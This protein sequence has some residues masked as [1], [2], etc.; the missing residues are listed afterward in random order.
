MSLVTGLVMTHVMSQVLSLLLGLLLSP[1]SPVPGGGRLVESAELIAMLQAVRE[2]VRARNP[3]TAGGAADV[4][5]PDLLPLIHA[6]DAALG[7]VAA[8]GSVNPRRGGPVNALVQSWKK[9]VARAL[10]WHVREQVEFN[11]KLVACVDAA[12]EALTENNRALVELGSRMAAAHALAQPMVE[13]MKDIRDHWTEWRGEWER[14]LERIE[15]QALRNMADLQG[16]FQHRVDRVDSTWRESL[17]AQHRAFHAELRTSADEIQRRLWADID[18]F[19]AEYERTIHAELRTVR[20]RAQIWRGAAPDAS[21]LPSPPGATQ[22]TPAPSFDYGKF[23]EKFRGPEEYVK[24]GQ[25]IYLPDFSGRQS[26]IDIGCGRGE[27]LET[28]RE[29]GVPARGIDLSEESVAMCRAK[30]LNAEVADLFAYLSDLPEASLDG[31]FCAQVVEHLA[32]ERLPEMIKLCAARLS[33]GG[34]IAIE[35]PNPECLAIFATHFY[36]DPTHTR[37]V[38]AALLAFYMEEFGVGRIE[39]RK[40]APAVESMPSLAEL[41]AAFRESFFGALDYAILGKKL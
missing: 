41:P 23:A 35:T 17:V 28:M 40:L 22:P 27:F 5:L 34:V 39:T 20:Q 9:L 2:R 16:A 19:R 3:Q 7:K 33:R 8:I 32:P 37:P 38:P 26:V 15:I 4:P 29:A 6:R 25:R 21:P 36:L 12:M 30:G 10:D 31:I 1:I 18:R 11:R 13:E 24:S 14:K